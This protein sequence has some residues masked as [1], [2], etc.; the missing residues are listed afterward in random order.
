MRTHADRRHG[1]PHKPLK[2]HTN[3]PRHKLSTFRSIRSVILLHPGREGLTRSGNRHRTHKHRLTPGSDKH[4][5]ASTS[6]PPPCHH[7]HHPV[8][9][10]QMRLALSVGTEAGDWLCLSGVSLYMPVTLCRRT[11]RICTGEGRICALK[12]HMGREECKILSLNVC[13]PVL[14]S[15]PCPLHEN[16]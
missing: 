14:L 12:I 9:Q 4:R 1:L 3:N 6:R 16:C 2:R 13:R 5:H 7:A 11:L 10:A 8:G 15:F